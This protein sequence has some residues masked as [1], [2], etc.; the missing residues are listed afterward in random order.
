MNHKWKI[1]LLA[2]LMT[3]LL[4]LGG[5]TIYQVSVD[6]FGVWRSDTTAGY[7]N[8]K[9][10]QKQTERVFKMYQYEMIKPEVA[11]FGSSRTNY[12]TPPEWPGVTDEKVYNFGITAVHIPEEKFYLDAALDIHTPGIVA[13]AVD[14]L[15]FSSRYNRPHKGYSEDR[16]WM[17]TFHRMTSLVS[18]LKD[19]VLSFDAIGSSM[20]VTEA[21]ERNPDATYYD[22]GWDTVRLTRWPTG[23]AKFR[24]I[25][26]R[27]HTNTYAKFRRSFFNYKK[28]EVMIESAK[29]KGVKV[30]MYT[31]PVHADFLMAYDINELWEEFEFMKREIVKLGPLW[32][33]NYINDVSKNRDNY[34]DPSHFKISIGRRITSILGNNASEEGKDFGVILTE[35]NIEKILIE[36]R[37]A[38]DEWKTRDTA[39]YYMLEEAREDRNKARF[40]QK[41]IRLIG[42]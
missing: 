36:Q 19:T 30:V 15:Q 17:M 21:S 14:L 18:K 35:D 33:F 39:V 22:R 42:R 31:N 2:F 9:I 20:E 41:A 4:C 5:I 26:F 12:C 38:F 27:Y 25:L 16:L 29:K 6:P 34:I 10:A 3:V 1:W 24:Q 28:F 11:F 37:S 23:R 7:N 8:Y 13:I 40:H 32:D